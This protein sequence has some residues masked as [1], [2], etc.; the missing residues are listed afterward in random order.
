MTSP[1]IHN[2]VVFNQGSTVSPTTQELLGNACAREEFSEGTT[3]VKY[4]AACQP[5]SQNKRCFALP[6]ILEFISYHFLKMCSL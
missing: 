6:R 5:V 4:A 2:V 1:N 3:D